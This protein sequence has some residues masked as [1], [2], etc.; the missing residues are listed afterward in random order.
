M[1]AKLY[2]KLSERREKGTLRSL[3]SFD[4]F[5][6]FFSNDY[7]GC[8]KYASSQA[9]IAGSTGSRLLSGNSASFEKIEEKFAWF[10]HSQSALHFNSGYDANLGIFSS[11]PQKGDT[12]IYDELI[13]AS[14]RDG[15]RLSWAKAYS[16]RHNDL[17]Q[18]ESRLKKAEGAIYVAIEALYSMDGDLAPLS[19]IAEL[20]EKY[21]A[22]LI[23]DEAHSGGVYGDSGKGLSEALGISD[24]IFIRLMTFGKAYG[25]HGAIALCDS[26]TREFL[27]NFC[28]PFIYSTVLPV[29]VIEHNYNVATSPDLQIARNRLQIV[30]KRFQQSMGAFESIS[31]PTSPI[32]IIEIGD[33]HKTKEISKALQAARIAV[34]PIF[35][36]TVPEGKERIRIC[37]HAFNTLEEIALLMKLLA[38]GD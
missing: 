24:K 16:F 9:S 34:K 13:H 28:R 22:F 30:L 31:D 26:D 2:K 7:L 8:A 18:L 6:D 23:V 12:I 10:F 20:C 14:V 32:Q 38:T 17:N 19:E 35:P 29:S 36:P 3:S 33:V 1:D 27:I 11:I 4:G 21:G 15:I 25:S 5:I 37:L